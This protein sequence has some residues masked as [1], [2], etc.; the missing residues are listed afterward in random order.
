MVSDQQ[1]IISA[2]L[3]KRFEEARRVLVLTGAGVSAESGVPTFRGRGRSAVWKGMPFDKIASAGMLESNLAEVWEWFNYRR[4]MIEKIAPNAAH[5][6]LARWR[7]RFDDFALV[8]QNVDGLHQAAG[9]SEVIELHG[10]VW[11]T[12]CLTCKA[13]YDLRDKERSASR[14]FTC[15]DCGNYLRPDVVLFGELLPPGAFERAAAKAGTCELCLVVGTSAIVYPAAALPEIAKAAGAYMVEIN[16]ERTP[17][18]RLCDE[19]INGKA[20]E[21][22]PLFEKQ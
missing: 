17:L 8:T 5:H 20:G 11:R 19:V 12:R 6:T 22:L 2:E 16:P 4:E 1:V 7:K 15:E 21:V 13:K 9:S 14:T 3:R 18:S 10:N